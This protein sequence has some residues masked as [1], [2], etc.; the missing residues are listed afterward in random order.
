MFKTGQMLNMLNIFAEISE[1]PRIRLGCP[2]SNTFLQA[3]RK[4]LLL[5]FGRK[6]YGYRTSWEGSLTVLQE[7]AL[8][9]LLVLP[10]IEG[11][12]KAKHFNAQN[13][14]NIKYVKHAKCFQGNRGGGGGQKGQKFNIFNISPVLATLCKKYLKF[15]GFWDPKITKQ[16]KC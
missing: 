12:E 2:S 5:D 11:V 13:R 15:P 3:P 9:V 10:N 6:E 4:L 1:K 8:T 7:P 14:G 16:G